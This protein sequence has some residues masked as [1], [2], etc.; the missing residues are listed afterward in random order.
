VYVTL[1]ISVYCINNYSLT[2]GFQIP[3]YTTTFSA[4]LTTV[5]SYSSSTN[6]IN[7][8]TNFGCANNPVTTINI[9]FAET[10]TV[11]ETCSFQLISVIFPNIPNANVFNSYA[12]S[13]AVSSKNISL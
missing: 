5:Y 11:V 12:L 1:L 10:V 2:V 13:A 3:Q 8:N 7:T 6:G 9:N 4:T